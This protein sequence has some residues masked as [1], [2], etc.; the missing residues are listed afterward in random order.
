VGV[1]GYVR[2]GLFA[3]VLVLKFYKI[4]LLESWSYGLIELQD[5]AWRKTGVKCFVMSGFR[6]AVTQWRN[7]NLLSQR[8]MA[9]AMKVSLRTIQNIELGKHLPTART[10]GKFY[11]LRKFY[12]GGEKSWRMK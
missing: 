1:E 3:H 6:L 7:A 10:R 5:F 8:Q 11:R 2:F 12:E 4:N 9:V